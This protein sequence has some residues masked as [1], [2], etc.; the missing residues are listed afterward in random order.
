MLEKIGLPPKPSMRGATW[1]LDASICQGC[2]AQFSLFTWKIGKAG[3]EKWKSQVMLRQYARHLLMDIA[4]WLLL[5]ECLYCRSLCRYSKSY[6]FVNIGD[7]L[8]ICVRLSN[9]M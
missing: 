7:K 2:A 5:F 9:V 1:V 8:L 4:C 3:G 6:V